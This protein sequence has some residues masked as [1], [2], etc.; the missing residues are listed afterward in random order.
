ME[1]PLRILAELM[2]TVY[3]VTFLLGP[4]RS[5]PVRRGYWVYFFL[6]V[7]A[8]YTFSVF[9]G[10]ALSSHYG[11]MWLLVIVAVE[12]KLMYNMNLLQLLFESSYFAAILYWG[13]GIVIPAFALCLD[14]SVQWVRHDEHYYAMAW[15]ISMCIILA[16]HG[17]FWHFLAQPAKIEKL[18]RNKPQL[19]FA[20]I[21]QTTLLAYLMFVNLG[22][23]YGVD[24]PWYKMTYIVSCVICFVAQYFIVR[25]GIRTCCLLEHE[26][27]TQILQ[28][29]LSRQV[30]HYNA[31]QKYTESFRAFKHDYKNMMASVN[32]LLAAGEYE[33]AKRMLDTIHDTMHKQVLVHKSY[34]NHMILDAILQDAANQCDEQ[35]I[36]FS[37][38]LYVPAG[39]A[40]EDIDIVR[41]FANLMNNAVEASVKV[42]PE[43]KRFLT[44]TSNVQKGTGWLSVEITNSF[45]GQLKMCNGMPESTKEHREMHGIGLS[46]IAD[47]VE[48]LGGVMKIDINQQESIFIVKLLFPV[49]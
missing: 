35:S 36:R 11:A 28:K 27:N 18:Y 14:Q 46:V 45:H 23:Y 29:Q 12:L 47:A 9:W 4:K 17:L 49:S 43:C 48:N 24:L 13:R 15:A 33:K 41:I 39:L 34:S 44:V 22:R 19:R 21:F 40:I 5:F 1:I 8:N 37:A 31:Y 25:N 26:L 3:S 16:Y 6:S 7:V 20:A 38:M 32:S 10:L 30:Q 42:F 2:F